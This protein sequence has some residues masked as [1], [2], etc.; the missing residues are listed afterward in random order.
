VIEKCAGRWSAES[1]KIDRREA[2]ADRF[3]SFGKPQS[4]GTHFPI[5]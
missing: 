3:E 5:D 4:R 1:L 2:F